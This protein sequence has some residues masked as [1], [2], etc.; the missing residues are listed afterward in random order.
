MSNITGISNFTLVCVVINI[1]S[2]I[3][4]YLK[5]LNS[6]HNVIKLISVKPHKT[7]FHASKLLPI[8]FN[9]ILVMKYKGVKNHF[10]FI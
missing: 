4:A 7:T 6:V 3:L 9:H 1:I 2:N 5:R 8:Y 10:D